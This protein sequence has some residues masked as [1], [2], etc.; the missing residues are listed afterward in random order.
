MFEMQRL[1]SRIKQLKPNSNLDYIRKQIAARSDLKAEVKQLRAELD[2]RIA[3]IEAGELPVYA[4]WELENQ[5]S[6]RM[7]TI[8]IDYELNAINTAVF[9]EDARLLWNE[10]NYAV[11]KAREAYRKASEGLPELRGRLQTLIARHER[12]LVSESNILRRGPWMPEH[13]RPEVQAKREKTAAF[14]ADKKSLESQIASTEKNA[15]RLAADCRQA[16]RHLEVFRQWVYT[17]KILQQDDF[18]P[19]QDSALNSDLSASSV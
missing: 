5:I 1:R 10:L 17:G 8:G 12:W 13:E 4:R 2:M 14:E 3:K 6:S 16:E 19:N 15:D 9:M 7:N 11:R 18:V